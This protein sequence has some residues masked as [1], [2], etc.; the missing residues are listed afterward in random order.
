MTRVHEESKLSELVNDVI[1][2]K[3]FLIT[4]DGKPVA[5]LLPILTKASRFPD[6]T[7]FR[8]SIPP[9]KMSAGQFISQMRDE[10]NEKF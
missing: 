5:K 4:R 7:D 8:A 2:G 3:E 6:L 10:D 1:K 9:S